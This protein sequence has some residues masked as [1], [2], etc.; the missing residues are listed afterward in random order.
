MGLGVACGEKGVV[1][2]G[3]LL[4]SRVLLSQGAD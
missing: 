2:M 4:L 3:E 1:E